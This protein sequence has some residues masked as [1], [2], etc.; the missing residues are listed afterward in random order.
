VLGKGGREFHRALGHER[1]GDV[2][3]S[4]VEECEECAFTDGQCVEHMDKRARMMTRYGWEIR[5]RAEELRGLG[6]LDGEFRPLFRE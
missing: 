6:V 2:K 1:D 3:M 5:R 4:D